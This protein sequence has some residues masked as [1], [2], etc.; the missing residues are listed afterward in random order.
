VTDEIFHD[1][2]DISKNNYWQNACCARGKIYSGETMID[3][4]N[5]AFQKNAVRPDP[6]EGQRA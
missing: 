3:I 5:W 6:L 2:S 4:C 1:T